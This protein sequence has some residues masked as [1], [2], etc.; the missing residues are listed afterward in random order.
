MDCRSYA[1][2]GKLLHL[3][4]DIT[5]GDVV[6]AFSRVPELES[7][8]RL[9]KELMDM[10]SSS[11][12]LRG[13][14]RT[15]APFLLALPGSAQVWDAASEYSSTQN[16]SG[17]WT[18]GWS[19]TRGGAVTPFSVY[20]TF[21]GSVRGW[22][23]PNSPY[24]HPTIAKNSATSTT[25]CGSVRMPPDRLVLHPGPQGQLAVLR[26]TAPVAS[27]YRVSVGF[28]GLDFSFPT[29]SDVE[30]RHNGSVL[31]FSEL[32]GF[33]GPSSCS[34]TDFSK[35]LGFV[36]FVTMQAGD[37]LDALVGY[38]QNM[39]FNGDSTL[40]EVVITRTG[41]AQIVGSS[42]GSAA[43]L[44]LS[45]PAVGALVTLSLDTAL[46]NVAGQIFL[47]LGPPT[48]LALGNGCTLYFDLPSILP[49]MPLATDTQGRWSLSFTIPADP[50]L[51]GLAF[52]LQGT[53]YPVANPL[54][55]VITNAIDLRL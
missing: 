17:A 8:R 52:V 35:P 53:L 7:S 12:S 32:L 44:D 30:V 41:S 29:N 36:G 2:G 37:T 25:C 49:L 15:I 10:R 6:G 22:L 13:C 20:G 38:G 14:L 48:P 42:C 1:R 50:L 47:S 3:L 46:P 19:A 4:G 34:S 45:T 27:T 18:Y 24:S 9:L 33:H 5:T 26:W 55:Y 39:R 40:A 51:N 21:C 11:L 28:G 54:G 43:T 16:P 31:Y 23:L